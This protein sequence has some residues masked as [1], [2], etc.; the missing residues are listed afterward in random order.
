M[1]ELDYN[2]PEHKTMC[3]EIILAKRL[4]R[5]PYYSVYE[6]GSFFYEWGAKLKL[7]TRRADNI[8]VEKCYLSSS[9]QYMFR[10]TTSSGITKA[11][12]KVPYEVI[13][14]TGGI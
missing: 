6:K 4:K 7:W 12:A 2:N 9:K 10:V 3:E 8:S 1:M 11:I 13:Q 5:L 14:Q